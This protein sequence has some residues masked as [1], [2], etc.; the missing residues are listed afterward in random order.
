MP[1]FTESPGED[2]TSPLLVWREEWCLGIEAL[3]T[4]HQELVR[5]LNQLLQAQA[6]PLAEG[7]PG[8]ARHGD[9]RPGR[10]QL[11]ILA[12]LIEHRRAHFRREEDLMAAIDYPDLEAHRGE[13]EMQTAELMDLWRHL[14]DSGAEHLSAESL[15]WIKRWC[16]DHF[17]TE[18]RRL[19]EAHLGHRAQNP[20]AAP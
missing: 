4:D 11:A 1:P 17:I 6:V 8:H 9:D 15:E 13:H 5:L 7:G 16:F 14:E 12:A 10:D 19:A 18:D 2:W 3:D 20:S